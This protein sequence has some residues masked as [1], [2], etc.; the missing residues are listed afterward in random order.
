MSEADVEDPVNRDLAEESQDE[1]ETIDQ[2]DTK[3]EG[4][5]DWTWDQL[6]SEI[7]GEDDDGDEDGYF[8]YEVELARVMPYVS[9]SH[10]S[11]DCLMSDW[12]GGL[13]VCSKRKQ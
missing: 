9:S 2:G 5:E 3:K 8:E 1:D 13:L 4:D 7:A 11:Y 10:R 6:V 12:F